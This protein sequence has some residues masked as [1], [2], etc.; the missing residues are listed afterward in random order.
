MDTPE[1]KWVALGD[2]EDEFGFSFQ[3]PGRVHEK[4]WNHK[5]I[6]GEAMLR[7]HRS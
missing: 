5:W 7:S 3:N 2:E 6:S 4:G 1:S